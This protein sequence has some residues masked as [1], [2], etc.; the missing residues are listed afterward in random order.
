[1]SVRADP[2]AMVREVFGEVELINEEGRVMPWNE[3]AE[4]IVFW[5][6]ILPKKDCKL[7]ILSAEGGVYTVKPF[8]EGGAFGH[9]G[10]V[11]KTITLTLQIT[12]DNAPTEHEDGRPQLT[13]KQT[14]IIEKYPFSVKEKDQA[15]TPTE[16]VGWM[17][18][19][20]LHSLAQALG[21][22]PKFVDG[23]GSSV[24]P[25]VN[26]RNGN[27]SAPRGVDGISKLLNPEFKN[28]FFDTDGNPLLEFGGKIVYGDIKIQRD[29]A[30][31]DKNQVTRFKR[32]PV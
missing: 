24:E 15:K 29:E 32:K 21:F 9:E 28:A 4:P 7:E 8:T 10:E 2:L 11:A 30:Y 26:P 6:P 27:K 25:Y 23:S 20:L 12:D 13:F 19:N 3:E 31:P 22:D 16:E 18:I 5:E 14:M 17:G 1:V